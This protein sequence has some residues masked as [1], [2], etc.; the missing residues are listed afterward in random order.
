MD[1]VER[2]NER[3]CCYPAQVLADKIYYNRENRRALK[4]FHIKLV[5]KPLGRLSAQAVKDHVRPGAR[6]P[7]EGS[8][9]RE[10]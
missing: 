5:A 10:R 1:S 7:I 3:F 2:Y 8:L 9:V 6:N 4:A